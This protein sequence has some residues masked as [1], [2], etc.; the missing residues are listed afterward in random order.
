MLVGSRDRTQLGT[1]HGTVHRQNGCLRPTIA[2]TL[3]NN[4]QLTKNVD[5]KP[6]SKNHPLQS[7]DRSRPLVCMTANNHKTLPVPG[8]LMISL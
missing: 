1:V 3:N 5:Q 2:K 6:S 7:G 4:I 8:V